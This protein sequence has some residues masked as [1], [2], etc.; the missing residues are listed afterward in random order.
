MNAFSY[1]TDRRSSQLM[2]Q[3]VLVV[4]KYQEVG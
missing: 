3:M 1:N 2:F 4:M